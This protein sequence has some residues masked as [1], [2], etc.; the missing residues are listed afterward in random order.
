MTLGRLNKERRLGGSPQAPVAQP[1][2]EW[3][4][5][6]GSELFRRFLQQVGGDAHVVSIHH[7]WRK[8]HLKYRDVT[9]S[10]TA[11]CSRSRDASVLNLTAEQRYVVLNDLF[12]VFN[13]QY[14]NAFCCH[15]IK[16]N[17]GSG[18]LLQ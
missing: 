2:L 5:D 4:G 8:K 10:G 6:R 18:A 17:N 13:E 14:Y 15:C 1:H 12:V 7:L 9:A 3:G 16:N 11:E